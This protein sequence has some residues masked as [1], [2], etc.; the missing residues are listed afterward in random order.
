MFDR[1]LNALPRGNS[2]STSLTKGEGSSQKK[3]MKNDTGGGC[4]AKKFLQPIFLATQFSL[5]LISLTGSNNITVSNNEKYP[6]GC[7]CL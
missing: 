4:D 3:V 6:K 7:M 1:V 5:L 2:E